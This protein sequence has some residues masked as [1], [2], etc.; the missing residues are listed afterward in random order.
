MLRDRSVRRSTGTF[1]IEGPV[2]VADALAAGIGVRE[3]FA[4]ADALTAELTGT[5]DAAGTEP[6]LV[7]GGGLAQVLDTVTPRPV[8]AV[9][10]LPAYGLH[11]AITDLTVVLV[12]VGDPGNVGTLVRTAEAAGA[13]AVVCCGTTADP[14]APKAVRA[15]AGSAFRLPVVVE[16]E[17]ATAMRTLASGGLMRVG[18][19]ARAAESYDAVDLTEP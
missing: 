3:V 5:L 17:T 2:L 10:T 7:R 1:A 13:G 11:E 9:A 12:D 16:P 8:V 15:S 4:E 14:F 18:L 6:V 19:A